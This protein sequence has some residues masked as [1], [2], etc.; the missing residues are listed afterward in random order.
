MNR[1]FSLTLLASAVGFLAG[2]ANAQTPIT[3]AA[4]PAFKAPLTPDGQPDLQGYWTND[5]YT[6][7]ERPAAFADKEFFTDE[8]AAA[9]VKSRDDRLNGQSATDI[10]YDDAIWQAE[11]YGKV[12]HRRTSLIGKPKNGRLPPLTDEGT[13]RLA[14]QRATQRANPALTG[15]PSRSLAERCITWGNVGPPMVPPTYNANLEILQAKDVV[16]IRHEMM[17]DTRM[18]YLDGRGHPSPRVQWLAGHS[19]GHWDG[20]TL[21]VDTTNFTPKTNFRGPPAS[22]RQ[23]IFATEHLHVVERFTPVDKDTIRY[24]FT[25]EDPATWTAPWSGEMEIRRTGE[26]IYE[27][28]CH[29]GNLGLANILRAVQL[30]KK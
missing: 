4:P 25:V 3:G 21:V 26:P 19:I 20:Q 8:E 1:R 22:T 2:V 7:L 14:Q 10:H 15:A 12:A 16:T 30:A 18:V 13:A 27:Y 11:N 23:D 5:T 29:E 9:F 28:A 17:H 24:E 6:P